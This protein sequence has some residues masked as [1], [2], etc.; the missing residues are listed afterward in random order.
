[1]QQSTRPHCTFSPFFD[2]DSTPSCPSPVRHRPR[3]P[4]SFPLPSPSFPL[5]SP[6]FPRRREP[7]G[8]AT[9]S[10]PSP[11]RHARESSNG[12]PGAGR[13]R[14]P[15]SAGTDVGAPRQA[16]AHKISSYRPTPRIPFLNHLPS[17]PVPLLQRQSR[18]LGA[19]HRIVNRVPSDHAPPFVIAREP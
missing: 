12:H 14:G 4:S 3:P 13:A 1:M 8:G 9:P 11:F 7:R 5:P 18:L 2:V 19:L 16:E 17:T 10:F 6:S 15:P